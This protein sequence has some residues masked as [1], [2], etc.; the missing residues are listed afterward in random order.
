MRRCLLVVLFVGVSAALLLPT[1]RPSSA[2]PALVD[3][4]ERRKPFSLELPDISSGLITAPEATIPTAELHMLRLRVANPYAEGINYGKIFTKIN[5]ESAGTIQES[6]A[7]S[8]GYIVLL[9]LDK[10]PRF[11]LQPGKN[12]IEI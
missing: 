7:S 8:S 6:R 5:G 3:E 10:K 12:V 9:D 1:L 4:S 2:A 11:R